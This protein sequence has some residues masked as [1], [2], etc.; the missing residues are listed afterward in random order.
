M[1][2]PLGRTTGWA[3]M[4]TQT[5]ACMGHVEDSGIE[6]GERA[7]QAISTCGREGGREGGRGGG[8]GVDACNGLAS[9]DTCGSWCLFRN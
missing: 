6:L 1:G 8:R 5:A 2:K 4:D 9:Q 3:L 7:P